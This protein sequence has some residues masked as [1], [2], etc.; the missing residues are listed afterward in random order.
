MNF[1][2]YI[3]ENN[4]LKTLKSFIDTHKFKVFDRSY[5]SSWLAS[6]GF[7]NYEYIE[8]S[9]AIA[10]SIVNLKERFG[11]PL[12]RAYQFKDVYLYDWPIE[13]YDGVKVIINGRRPLEGDYTPPAF[14]DV[15]IEDN[16]NVR[17]I[18]GRIESI[19]N[20][21]EVM[22]FE[23]NNKLETLKSFINR[24]KIVEIM[25]PKQIGSEVYKKMIGAA[26][27]I[28]DMDDKLGEGFVF[29]HPRSPSF[30]LYGWA[31]KFADDAIVI[32]QTGFSYN[33]P[34]FVYDK[35]KNKNK[36][37]HIWSTLSEKEILNRLTDNQ[38]PL[39][40]T[41]FRDIDE[42]VQES[43]LEGFKS[44]MKAHKFK[45]LSFDEWL[46]VSRWLNISTG[47]YFLENVSYEDLFDRM[48]EIEAEP[49]TIKS[50][51]DI[52]VEF[53]SETAKADWYMQFAD[54][55][56]VNIYGFVPREYD[57]DEGTYAPELMEDE[58][59]TWYIKVYPPKEY[60]SVKKKLK[61]IIN[62]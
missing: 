21:E 5:L 44:Y 23:A 53:E 34:T 28:G 54:D 47:E 36:N 51:G 48:Q 50:Q 2:Q 35:E 46:P 58:P 55:T 33:N 45:F 10:T 42:Q 57:E 8:P 26:A 3:K 41:F 24:S 19:V 9:G 61:D 11:Q 15:Y 27:P 14:W 13:F 1:N 40:E 31:L 6:Y 18:M 43:K 30:F 59:V 52:D 37:W 4:K 22:I 12:E 29:P 60:D 62:L 38:L 17:E 25:S 7:E 16:E 20:P 56:V 32:I 49:K 39:R